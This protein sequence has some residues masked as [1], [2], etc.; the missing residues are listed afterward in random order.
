[1]LYILILKTKY[2]KNDNM[3]NNNSTKMSY[4]TN[5]TPSYLYT[6]MK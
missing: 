6:L 1:M 3:D 2:V 5:T 4:I